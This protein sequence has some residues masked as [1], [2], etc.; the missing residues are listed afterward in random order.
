[1]SAD[2]LVIP[3]VAGAQVTVSVP[4]FLYRDLTNRDITIETQQ[5]AT[6]GRRGCIGPVS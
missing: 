5:D 1:M 3:E 6:R 4:G 2:T